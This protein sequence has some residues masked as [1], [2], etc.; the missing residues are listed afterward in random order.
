[1]IVNGAFQWEPFC[2]FH[3]CYSDS[4]P[5]KIAEMVNCQMGV[6]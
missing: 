6:N 1:M 2:V 5:I 3:R 4:K